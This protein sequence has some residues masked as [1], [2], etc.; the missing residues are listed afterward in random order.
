MGAGSHYVDEAKRLLDER[1][2]SDRLIAAA[3][4]NATLAV[5]LEIRNLSNS[6]NQGANR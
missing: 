3:L 2:S 6:L 5:A 4:V 1:P